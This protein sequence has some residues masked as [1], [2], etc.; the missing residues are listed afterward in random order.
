MP[1]K[2]MNHWLNIAFRASKDLLADAVRGSDQSQAAH[3]GKALIGNMKYGKIFAIR[4]K[5]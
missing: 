1:F 4:W 2:S 5:C 3:H